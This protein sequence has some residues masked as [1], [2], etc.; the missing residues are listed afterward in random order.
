[1]SKDAGAFD[2]VKCTHWAEGGKG[3][4]ALAEAVE[5]ASQAVSHFKFLY[6]VEVRINAN[7]AGGSGGRWDDSAAAKSLMLKFTTDVTLPGK[8]R[9]YHCYT[10]LGDIE[11]RLL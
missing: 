10:Y 11:I 7:P 5:R 3:A 8:Q 4:V 2:A 9:P 6:D 1:M